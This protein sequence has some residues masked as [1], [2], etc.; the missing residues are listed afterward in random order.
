MTTASVCMTLSGVVRGA[1]RLAPLAVFMTP[2]GMAYGVA[3]IESGMSSAHAIAS[4]ILVYSAAAQFTAVDFWGPDISLLALFLVTLAVSARHVIMG[5][6][7]SPW[8]NQLDAKRRILGAAFLSDPNFAYAHTA[9]KQNENDVGVLVGAG[10][11]TWS[12]WVLGTAVGAIAGAQLGDPR[13]YGI[14][15]LMPVYF[16]AL[17]VPGL[18]SDTRWVFAV[19]AALV[20]V[21][22]QPFVPTGW[23][24]I[25]AA[26]AGG[27]VGVWT[28][29]E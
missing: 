29:D 13:T 14:D 6:A 28:V 8:V 1:R 9:L 24:I 21:A 25:L 19:V 11:I 5:A 7:L 4:S 20:A 16:A 18:L 27:V 12:T 26:L 3:A 22:S 23:N 15:V 2:L 17:V 10:A